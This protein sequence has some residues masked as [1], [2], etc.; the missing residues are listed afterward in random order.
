[1]KLAEALLEKKALGARITDLNRRFSEAALVEE[2]T[3]GLGLP[4]LVADDDEREDAAALLISLHSAFHRWEALTVSINTSNNSTMVGERT[5]MQA[6]A[7]RDALKSQI[8]HFANIKEQIRGRN[9]SRR[10]YGENA[11][12][13]LVAPGVSLAYFTK[14]VDDLSQELRLLDTSIQAANWA[15]DLVE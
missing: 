11:P 12:K 1:M 6:L 7:H 13:M 9:Q 2:P 14:L 15:F 4:G 8:Q 3:I 5:M 10:M